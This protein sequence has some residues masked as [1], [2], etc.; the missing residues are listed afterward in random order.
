V[1]RKKENLAWIAIFCFQENLV[2]KKTNQTESNKKK[3]KII[4]SK[5]VS[6]GP[7]ASPIVPVVIG[8]ALPSPAVV[9]SVH[10]PP[11]VA[12]PSAAVGSNRLEMS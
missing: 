5:C 4:H 7:V 9:V 3:G 10:D 8:V 6:Y 11:P 2:D 12:V 1:C